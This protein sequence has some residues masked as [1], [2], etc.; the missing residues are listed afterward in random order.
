M[1]ALV[2]II[3]VVVLAA[4]AASFGADSRDYEPRTAL[5]EPR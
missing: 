5:G 3:A 1:I 4:V 2:M